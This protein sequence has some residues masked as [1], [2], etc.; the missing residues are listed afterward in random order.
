MSIYF[1]LYSHARTI[2]SF[3]DQLRLRR[4]IATIN[5]VKEKK[6]LSQNKRRFRVLRLQRFGNTAKQHKKYITNL[7]DYKLSPT[8]IFVLLHGLDFCLPPTN[9]KSEKNFAEFEVLMAQ[10]EHNRPQL[11][12]KH[13]A[14]K[15]ILSNMEHV[16][17]GKPI[18]V[19]DFLMHVDFSVL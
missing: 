5:N 14:L 18:D 7:F 3:F 4:Y 9:S 10:L 17:C 12:E 1:T 11:P 13:S 19:G 15:A 2:L 16:Y 6:N 8:Q